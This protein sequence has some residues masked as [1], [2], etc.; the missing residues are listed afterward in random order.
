MNTPIDMRFKSGSCE[1][2][3]KLDATEHQTIVRAR[4]QGEFTSYRKLIV[5]LCETF[6]ETLEACT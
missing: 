4:L 2:R 1:V 6:L 5:S 3:L